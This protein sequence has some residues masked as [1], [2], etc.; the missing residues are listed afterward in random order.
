MNFK[1]G[2]KAA[3]RWGRKHQTTIGL[4][5][6]VVGVVGSMVAAGKAAIEIDAIMQEYT[7]DMKYYKSNP[8]EID[9]YEMHDMRVDYAREVLHIAWKP[10]LLGLLTIADIILLHRSHMGIEATLTSALAA[11]QMALEDRKRAEREILTRPRDIQD[12]DQRYE[13]IRYERVADDMPHHGSEDD[14][15]ITNHGS[16]LFHDSLTGHNFRMCMDWLKNNITDLNDQIIREDY[17]SYDEFMDNLCPG[18]RIGSAGRDYEWTADQITG[19]NK[20]RHDIRWISYKDPVT[21]NEEPMGVLS[22][23]PEP[24]FTRKPF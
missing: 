4:G 22:F 20:V 11:S 17:V 15:F 2:L 14:I 24:Q 1:K 12:I 19:G 8:D 3:G 9:D 18:L 23:W 16:Q 6:A 10:A 7:E 5:F 21:G 13:E